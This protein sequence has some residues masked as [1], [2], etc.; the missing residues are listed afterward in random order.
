MP[1]AFAR[2]HRSVITAVFGVGAIACGV[3]GEVLSSRGTRMPE[4]AGAKVYAV[5]ATMENGAALG[6][7]CKDERAAFD[8]Y[9]SEVARLRSARFHDSLRAIPRPSGTAVDSVAIRLSVKAATI[10]AS[11]HFGFG[12]LPRGAY[13]LV[14]PGA[15]WWGVDGKRWPVHV[16]KLIDDLGLACSIIGEG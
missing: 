12:R 16:T 2:A 1:L 4:L 5:P 11:G 6:A 15:G 14:L 8:R 10:D 7:V 3:S 9:R 13:Y